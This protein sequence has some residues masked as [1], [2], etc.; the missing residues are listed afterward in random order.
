M[1]GVGQA[2]TPNVL[3]FFSSFPHA[4]S[5]EKNCDVRAET[6][7]QQTV[8]VVV[9]AAAAAV[10]VAVVLLTLTHRHTVSDMLW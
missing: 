7:A 4:D 2:G 5:F 6:E 8:V 9:V 1:T 10:A 3:Q